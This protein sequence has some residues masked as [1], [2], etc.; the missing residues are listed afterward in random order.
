MISSAVKCILFAISSDTIG[1]RR[2]I[3]LHSG[4][5]LPKNIFTNTNT[6][7]L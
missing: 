4:D 1:S 5:F 7:I 2:F 3:I 6:V